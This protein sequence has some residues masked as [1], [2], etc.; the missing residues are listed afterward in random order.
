MN[1]QNEDNNN[2]KNIKLDLYNF[3]DKELT[4]NCPY[5]LTSPRSLKACSNRNVRPI[6]LLYQNLQEFIENNPEQGN[7][8]TFDGM[9]RLWKRQE[10]VKKILLNQ[11]RIERARLMKVES[12]KNNLSVISPSPSRSL[13][14]SLQMQL[15]HH[16]SPVGNNLQPNFSTGNPYSVSRTPKSLLHSPAGSRSL[17]TDIKL[18]ELMKQK[19]QNQS[20][21]REEIF[22]RNLEYSKQIELERQQRKQQQS[23]LNRLIKKSQER[24][25]LH[26]QARRNLQKL[27]IGSEGKPLIPALRSNNPMNVSDREIQNLVASPLNLSADQGVNTL[28]IMNHNQL[29]HSDFNEITLNTNGNISMPVTSDSERRALRHAKAS[30]SRAAK[31]QKQVQ[32]IIQENQHAQERVLAKRAIG[33]LERGFACIKI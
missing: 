26:Q 19:R 12:A 8:L 13:S 16:T 18:T 24:W 22:K 6:D 20:K 27:K 14:A 15:N 4:A 28:Q 9:K 23:E 30:H 1:S 5:V 21:E 31:K 17:Y 2:T 7:K 32:L 11:C 25:N 3:Q 10:D 33:D 29:S